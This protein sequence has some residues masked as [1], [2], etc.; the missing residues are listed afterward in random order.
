MQVGH[1]LRLAS[2]TG[3]RRGDLVKLGWGHIGD[4]TIAKPTTK[5][6]HAKTTFIPLLNETRALPDEIRA[7]RAGPEEERNRKGKPPLLATDAVLTNSR[8][9]AWTGDGLETQIIRPRPGAAST[10]TC[11]TR[12]GPL[13]RACGWPGNSNGHPTAETSPKSWPGSPRGWTGC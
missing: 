12:A 13:P 11:T 7:A 6:R 5:S 3:L 9:K 2:L 1:A 10:S 8:G 4:L